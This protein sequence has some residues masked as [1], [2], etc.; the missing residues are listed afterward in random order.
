MRALAKVR[1]FYHSAFATAWLTATSAR[2]LVAVNQPDKI[3]FVGEAL[4]GNEAVD[5]LTRFDRSL[6]D[7]SGMSSASARGID[8]LILTKSVPLHYPFWDEGVE[9]FRA[10]VRYHRRQGR[11]GALDDLRHRMPAPLRRHGSDVHRLEGS[12]D[13]EHRQCL[14]RLIVVCIGILIVKS[15]P[16]LGVDKLEELAPILLLRSGLVPSTKRESSPTSED[17]L[18]ENWDRCDATGF[19]ARDMRLGTCPIG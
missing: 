6:R 7:F 17:I 19:P 1:T 4:V 14:D 9:I 13:R 15:S 10:Q 16:L 5:Q 3:V 11:R 18:E 8:G 2:Q 12:P